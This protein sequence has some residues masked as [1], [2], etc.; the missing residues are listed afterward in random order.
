M[1]LRG[2]LFDPDAR[3]CP[4]RE[5]ELRE[6]FNGVRWLVRAGAAWRMM[7][8]DLPPWYTVYQHTQCWLSVGVFEAMLYD[9][10]A[11]LRLAAGRAEQPSAAIF[12]GQTLQSS[13]KAVSGLVT[14]VIN[15]KRAAKC[16]WR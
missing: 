8:N 9:L 2:P 14:M 15:V 3:R 16:I 5:H 10:R 1:G 13:R 6:V 11:L 12:D 4:Q 7:P